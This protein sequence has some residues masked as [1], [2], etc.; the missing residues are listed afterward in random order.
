M[1]AAKPV[2]LTRNAIL[3][4]RR[5]DGRPCYFAAELQRLTPEERREYDA[6][7]QDPAVPKSALYRALIARG[8]QIATTPFYNHQRRQCQQCFGGRA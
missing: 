7:T 5:R 1:K 2:P 3:E 8:L 6:A 4:H